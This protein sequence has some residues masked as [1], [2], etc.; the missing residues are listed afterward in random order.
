MKQNDFDH[1]STDIAIVGMGCLFPKSKGLQEFWRLIYNGEDAI[2][3]VPSSHW[4]SED[5]FDADPK[6]ADHTYCDRGGFLSQT[7]F[8][9][10]EFGIPPNI[11]A[12]TDTSQ[13][14]GLVVAKQALEDAGYG[15]SKEF[16]KE[17]VSVILGVTGTQELVIPLGARLGHP[18]WRKACEKAG[19]PAEKVDEVVDRISDSYVKW[20]ENSFPGLL[21][22]VVAGRIANRFNLGGTNCVVDAAC[23]SSLAALHM[24]AMELL[25][26]K[27]NMVISGGVDTL[28]DIFMYMCFSKTPALSPTGDSKPF[29]KNAD[30]T[31]LGEGIGMV[32]LKRLDDAL[33]DNDKIYAVVKG[34]GTSSDGRSQSIYAPRKEGQEKAL[35]RAYSSAGVTPDTIG[36]VEAHGTGTKVG[37]GVEISALKEVF[38]DVNPKSHQVAIGSIKSQIGHTKAAAGI[39]GVIKTALAL[40]H[41][42]IPPTIKASD[43]S[44]SL[45][46]DNPFYISNESR[47]WLVQDFPRRAAVSSFGFGGSNY[48]VAL[49]EYDDN[50]AHVSWQREIELI[51]FSADSVEAVANQLQDY[52]NTLGDDSSYAERQASRKLRSEFNHKGACRLVLVL[53][54]GG[55]E[56]RTLLEKILEHIRK[57]EISELSSM[58]QV[59]WGEGAAEDK[60][61]FLFPGQGSQYPLMGRDIMCSFPEGNAELQMLEE[62]EGGRRLAEVVYPPAVFGKAEIKKQQAVLTETRYAQPAIGFVSRMMLRTLKRFGLKPDYVAGHSYGELVALYAAGCIDEQTLNSLSMERG[63][64]MFDIKGDCGTMLAVQGSVE[65]LELI[66]SDVKD[67]VL[68][69]INSLK[70]GVLSGTKPAIERCRDL[71]NE[72][73]LSCTLLPV[74][75]AFHSFI[76]EP[77]KQSFAQ[78]I[79]KFD[80]SKPETPVLAGSMGDLYPTDPEQIKNILSEQLT[81][82]VNFVGMLQTL[83]KQG[84]R[85]F[86]EVGPKTVL[87]GLVKSTLDRTK[88]K[89]LSLDQSRGRKSGVM[90]LASTLAELAALG[91]FVDLGEWE[92]TQSNDRQLKMNIPLKGANYSNAKDERPLSPK[93]IEKKHRETTRVR[94][95]MPT[96]QPVL[97]GEEKTMATP[98]QTVQ[99]QPIQ[100]S[101]KL[102]VDAFKVVQEGLRSIQNLQKETAEVHKRFLEGQDNANRTLQAMMMQTQELA[103]AFWGVPQNS[104]RV[105]EAPVTPPAPQKETIAPYRET[106][107][108]KPVTPSY[109]P[110][111][112]SE[113]QVQSIP[114]PAPVTVPVQQTIQPRAESR[115]QIVTTTE[116]SSLSSYV[117][118]EPVPA[119]IQEKDPEPAVEEISSDAG[120][121]LEP[122]MLQIVSDLTG[123]PTEMLGMDMDIEADLGI[124]SIKRVEILSKLDEQSPGLKQ[125]A[126][127]DMGNL[128]TL[129]QILDYLTPPAFNTDPNLAKQELASVVQVDQKKKLNAGL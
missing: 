54:E 19:L 107:D 48:H 65:D 115:S 42:V 27:A 84:V 29:S 116:S 113:V 32:V 56:A 99:S 86:V 8:D 67:V 17:A 45:A 60:V 122:I 11:L 68:A 103:G 114:A 82:S 72:L 59:H 52:I 12:A 98:K 2:D 111:E 15:E 44:E 124:D 41:K 96:T 74:S 55:K 47:P 75:A 28:N 117:P 43:P 83:Y 63:R 80:F 81:E 30:G 70:Q 112:E 77:A 104:Q 126:P 53:N 3:K 129:G 31:V 57:N 10:T 78:F 119:P 100:P 97:N 125:V 88:I 105:V 18:I 73:K 120:K 38:K 64:L 91:Q 49:Q 7:P 87:A 16:D 14:L 39:A 37:D 102:L 4:N 35:N 71:C 121:S 110:V 76:M 123:Y 25:S 21:G 128:R 6:K 40:Y 1:N 33:E 106:V 50:K 36:L 23:A 69:N 13:L 61:A 20:E 109:V 93:M 58:K 22:N 26:G 24:G 62:F 89:V 118:V 94:E 127:E 34:I 46:E 92:N 101:D 5:Y 85:T 90:D 66:A 108:P 95:K 79:K 9:P 51:P